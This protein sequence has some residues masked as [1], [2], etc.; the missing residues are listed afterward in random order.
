MGD[1]PTGTHRTGD[2]TTNVH[3]TNDEGAGDLSGDD[4][5][6][7][8]LPILTA[9]DLGADPMAAYRDWVDLARSNAVVDPD[10]AV[11]AT[12]TPD[13]APSARPVLIRMVD[14]D[15][16]VFFTNLDSRKGYEVVAN[17]Q[18][19]VTAV[20]TSQ[21][22]CVRFEGRAEHATAAESDAYWATRPR[23][24]RLAAVA[25]PQSQRISRTELETRWA[26]MAD[27][28]RGSPIPRPDNWGGIRVRPSRVEFWQGRTFRMHD[29]IVYHRTGEGWT[30]ERLAP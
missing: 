25:S 5:P 24:S 26:R 21:H 7:G 27:R 29:R 8:N 30:T 17:P 10:A 16:L 6:R 18:V 11:V 20:W 15:G 4:L 3:G 22:R 28:Y 2:N 1:E 13:G 9:A 19:A 23:G 14:D 12:A